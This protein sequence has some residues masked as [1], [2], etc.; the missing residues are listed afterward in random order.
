MNKNNECILYIK[1]NK[2]DF[3]LKLYYRFGETLK[4]TIDKYNE[5]GYNKLSYS[6]YYNKYGQLIPNDLPIKDGLTIYID[7][8]I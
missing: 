4:V 8:S 1:S 7:K 3:N 5:L 2:R 6:E